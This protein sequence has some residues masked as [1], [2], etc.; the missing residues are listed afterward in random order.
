MGT[1][2]KEIQGYL[3]NRGLKYH[4]VPERDHILTGFQ[5]ERYVHTDGQKH[6][7]VVIQ[8]HENGEYVEIFSPE[9]YKYKEGPHALAVMQACMFVSWRT[10]MIQFEYDPSDGEIRAV[11]EFP[12]EDAHMTEKQFMRV[13]MGLPQLVDDYDPVIRTA[14]EHGRLDPSL[15]PSMAAHM[16]DMLR[17]LLQ[18]MGV[19]SPEDIR[20]LIES[21]TGSSG[22]PPKPSDGAPEAL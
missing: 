3:E 22:Q 15:C 6:L 7:P 8:L 9:V 19:T 14:I 17:G 18:A 5:M 2:L 10:K 11:I 20:K 21:V 16:G 13:L 1:T 4:A 12:L